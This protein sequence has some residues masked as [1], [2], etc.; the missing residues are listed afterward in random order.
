MSNKASDQLHKLIKSMSKPEKRYF[1][2]FSSRHIIGDE[3]NYQT[4]FDAIDKQEEYDEEKLLKKLKDKGFVNRF[5][6][7]KN[8]L[9]NA[10]LKSLDSFH[11]NSSIEAQIHRQVHAAE[12]LYNKSLYDQSLKVL[13]SARKVAEKHELF[14]VLI[15]ISK[16]EKR[17]LEKGNYDDIQEMSELDEIFRRDMEIHE[18]LKTTEEL[19]NIKSKIF[20]QLYRQGKVRTEEETRHFKKL[21]DDAHQRLAKQEIGVENEYL[22]RHISSAYH[23]A[24]GEYSL[25]YPFLKEN[26]EIIQQHPHLFEEEPGI[27]LSVLSNTIYVG[28]RL[29]QWDEAFKYL[30]ELRAFPQTLAERMN[31]DLEIRLFSLGKSTELA[32][33]AQSGEF[34]KGLEIIPE[35]KL[36]LGAFQEHLSN[37]RKAHFYFNIAVIYFGLEQYHEALKWVNKLLNNVDIDKSKDIH[38]IAQILNLVIHL[39]LGN[40]ELLPYTLRSTQ[41]FL[42]TRNKVFEFE[43]VMLSFVNEMLKKRTNKSNEDLYSDLVEQLQVLRSNPFE[44]F[45]F[46]YFDFHSWAK[47]KAEG[48]KFREQL[49][50]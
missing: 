41:R 19:W 24:L 7:A 32:L 49:V 11:S 31:E 13:H 39:E 18:K 34:E 2:V 16:W 38:C 50:A 46:E 47:S 48:K 42:A 5:S 27:Y 4:L 45:V 10:L 35:I 15:E 43:N 26:I 23:F 33:Y 28:M 29:G 37:V 8:R 6:I 12:I 25:C 1:K 14:T 30:D 22:L 9:Y 44:Q 17:I 3:N 20:S 21:I 36:G 40:K